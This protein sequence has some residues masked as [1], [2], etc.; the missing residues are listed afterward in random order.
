M[1]RLFTTIAVL[2]VPTGLALLFAPLELAG[3][4]LGATLQ[5]AAALVIARVAGAAL[6]ALGF[7]C[8]LARNDGPSPAAR[9]LI[10]ALLL[11]N[12]AVAALLVHG[13][14]GLQLD[15]VGLWPAVVVHAAVA[16]WCVFTLRSKATGVVKE[17]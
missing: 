9:G 1:K 14:V 12:L 7:A 6:L 2:E 17:I 3:V 5:T 10:A 15:G 4:L 11:Y 8:W 16:G 13:A